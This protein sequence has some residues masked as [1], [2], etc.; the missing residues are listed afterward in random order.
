MLV[1]AV[2]RAGGGKL[3]EF[4]LDVARPGSHEPILT[5]VAPG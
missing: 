5:F 4:E 2:E 1:G 3:V